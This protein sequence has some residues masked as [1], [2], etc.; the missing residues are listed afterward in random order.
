MCRADSLRSLIRRHDFHLKQL[1]R[2]THEKTQHRTCAALIALASGCSKTTGIGGTAGD[3]S[4]ET[5][6]ANA[7]FAKDLK[8]DDQQDFETPSAASLPSPAARSP[9]RT[10]PCSK[11]LTPTTSSMARPADTVNPSLWRHAQLNANLACSR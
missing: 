1:R 10:A 6:K 2:Q 5:L 4:R 3:A 11:T 8:L 7:Q 9:R